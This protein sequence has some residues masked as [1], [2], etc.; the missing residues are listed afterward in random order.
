[1]PSKEFFRVEIE[2]DVF[3]DAWCIKPPEFDAGKQYPLLVFVYGEPAGRTVLDR[4]GTRHHPWH[5]MLAQQGYLI[6]SF[7]NRGDARAS[8]TWLAQV[9][10]SQDRNPGPQ[11][12]GSGS[13]S[14]PQKQALYRLQSHRCVGLERRRVDEPERYLQI[15]RFV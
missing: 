10:L 3:L 2:D 11:R 8:G 5:L 13:A 1:M 6:M 15:P 9:R 14:G 12:S 7:D 4:W